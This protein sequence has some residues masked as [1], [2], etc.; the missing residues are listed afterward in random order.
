MCPLSRR[1]ECASCGHEEHLLRCEV[2]IIPGVRCPCRD[3]P[4][5]GVYHPEETT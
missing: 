5:P 3:V 1:M 4:V 2:V